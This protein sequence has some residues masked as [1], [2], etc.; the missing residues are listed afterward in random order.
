[1]SKKITPNV[2]LVFAMVI[3][4][5][6]AFLAPSAPAHAQVT[7]GPTIPTG[8]SATVNESNQVYIFW[9]PSTETSTPVI[10]Y[11]LYRNG[12]EIANTPGYTFYID[13]AP[14]GAYSYTVAAY[15]GVGNISLQ[16]PPTPL[17]S[18]LIDDQPP[19]APT[20]LT[21]AVSSSSVTLSWN[22]ST[23]N[24]GVIGYYIYRNDQRINNTTT[25]SGTTY[26]D[27]GIPEGTAYIYSVVAYDAV[28]N[29]SNPSNSVTATTIFDVQAPTAPQGLTAKA[30]SPSEIDLSWRPATDN[31]EVAGYDIYQDGSEIATVAGTSTTY[32]DMELSAGTSYTYYI[33][34]FDEVGNTSIEGPGASATTMPPDTMPPSIPQNFYATPI[35]PSQVTLTW[36]PSTDNVGVAGY[37][38]YNG[39]TEVGDTTSTTYTDSN[40][41][42]S[43]TYQ[44]FISAY[45]AAGNISPQNS[46]AVKTLAYT[47]AVIVSPPTTTPPGSGQ[48]PP[49]ATPPIIINPI[50]PLSPVT[51][52]NDFIVNMYY[53][54]RGTNVVALQTFLIAQG[55]LGANYGTGF[56]GSLTQAAVKKFQCA[57]GIVCSGSPATTGW[58]SV[59]PH[60]RRVLN[61]L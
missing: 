40:L 32:A 57:E 20:G 26:V 52:T 36:S 14:A 41:A 29:I 10:G 3:I 18:V 1:M 33:Y 35:S 7:S 15:D 24:F 13:N 44:Y 4:A 21:A 50:P 54:S 11:Y 59:G 8:L 42:T 39:T 53:G 30:V 6:V 2:A 49:V 9:N 12:R 38:I 60:T 43:T 23:D 37:Y 46:V 5:F 19:T 27:S 48:T 25:I 22:A 45:D 31:I 56:Y 47:P 16:T 61:S 28:G 17:V 51:G 34:A 55:D 58:G